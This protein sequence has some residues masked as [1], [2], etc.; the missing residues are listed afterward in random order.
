MRAPMTGGGA[1]A[2]R[3]V[4]QGVPTTGASASALLSPMTGTDNVFLRVGE[5][6]PGW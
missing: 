2:A 1:Q 6:H 4:W 3:E 5:Q